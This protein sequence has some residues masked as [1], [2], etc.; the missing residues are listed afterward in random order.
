MDL[1]R[2]LVYCKFTILLAIIIIS[3]IIATDSVTLSLFYNI[4][5]I[6]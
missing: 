4:E 3:I 6:F 1:E 5:M 2:C